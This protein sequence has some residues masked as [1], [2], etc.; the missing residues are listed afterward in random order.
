[1][2]GS[3]REKRLTMIIRLE[4]ALE[5]G[6]SGETAPCARRTSSFLVIAERPPASRG[7]RSDG[8]I[9][10]NGNRDNVRTAI[11]GCSARRM[12]G[13]MRMGLQCSGMGAARLFSEAASACQPCWLAKGAQVARGR[14]SVRG[15]VLASAAGRLERESFLNEATTSIGARRQA[16]NGPLC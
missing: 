6:E 13:A 14:G 15:R 7:H 10:S 3:G 4:Y 5:L 12:T 1:M 9:G 8:S 2:S 11:D 16:G